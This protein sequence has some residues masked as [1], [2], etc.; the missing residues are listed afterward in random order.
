MF[1]PL[2]FI[3]SRSIGFIMNTVPKKCHAYIHLKDIRYTLPI[4][5]TK[6]DCVIWCKYP[7]SSKFSRI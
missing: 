2:N 3:I 7:P 1:G 5:E 6:C 4:L